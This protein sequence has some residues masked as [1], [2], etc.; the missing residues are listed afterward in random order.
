MLTNKA[1]I[2]CESIKTTLVASMAFKLALDPWR[3]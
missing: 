1:H 3:K 2:A